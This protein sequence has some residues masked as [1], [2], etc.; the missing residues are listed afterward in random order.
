M[1]IYE[2]AC[3]SCGLLFERLRPMSRMDDDSPCPDCDGESMRQLS[4]FSAF[5]SSSD[6]ED[7]AVAGGGGGCGGCSGGACACSAGL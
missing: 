3:Q 6:G 4:V 1:P 5:T 2:Y 7:S